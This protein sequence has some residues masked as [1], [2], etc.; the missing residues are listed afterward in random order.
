M[1]ADLFKEKDLFL[2]MKDYYNKMIVYEFELNR[3]DETFY[4]NLK[5]VLFFNFFL[6]LFCK[7]VYPCY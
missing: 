6:N 1:K 7:Y 2:Q 4:A 5:E 3:R